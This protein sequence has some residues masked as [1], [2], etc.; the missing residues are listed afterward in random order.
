MNQSCN[1]PNERFNMAQTGQKH[2]NDPRL[3]CQLK[4]QF[5]NVN[6]SIAHSFM[7]KNILNGFVWQN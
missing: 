4:F 3:T 2:P 6:L 7:K 1:M 5:T